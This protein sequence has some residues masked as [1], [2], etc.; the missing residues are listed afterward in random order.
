MTSNLE[1][2]HWSEIFGDPIMTTA[3]LDRLTHHAHLF[4]LTG[5]SY[6]FRDAKARQ[7]ADSPIVASPSAE[8]R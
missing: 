4:S 5:E 8:A 3:L 6:R 7:T 2:N 1:F